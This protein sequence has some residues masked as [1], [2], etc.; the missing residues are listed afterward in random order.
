MVKLHTTNENF[1]V[2]GIAFLMFKVQ[3]YLLLN[4]GKHKIDEMFK[5]DDANHSNRSKI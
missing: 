3:K 4:Q 1:I 5:Q 2:S